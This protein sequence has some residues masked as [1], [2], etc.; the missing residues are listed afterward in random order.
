MTTQE[1]PTSLD[2][3][4][5]SYDGFEFTDAQVAER[6]ANDAL[7]GRYCWTKELGWLQWDKRRWQEISN[8]ILLGVVR[9]WVKTQ[10]PCFRV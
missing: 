3:Y 9:D 6:F 4:V 8:P 7:I 2:K 10:W 1:T 5:A